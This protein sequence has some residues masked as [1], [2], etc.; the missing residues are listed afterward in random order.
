MLVLVWPWL[1]SLLPAPLLM[2]FFAEKTREQPLLYIPFAQDFAQNTRVNHSSNKQPLLW[3]AYL[4]WLLLLCTV[5]RPEWVGEAV[6]VPRS[7]RD[8][9]LAVDL[10]GSMQVKDFQLNGQTVNRLE[11]IKSVAGAFI[12]QREGD[13]LALILF[14]EQA[15][16]QTPLT[17]DRQTVQTLLNE[18]V[19]GMAGQQT[20]IGDAIGLALKHLDEDQREQRVLILLTDGANTAGEVS[21]KKAAELAKHAGLTIYTI[22]VGADKMLIQT[23]FG[24]QQVNPSQDLD[25]KTLQ[26]IADTTGGRYFRARNSAELASIYQLLDELEPVAHEEEKFRPRISLY[27]W[28]LGFALGLF[29]LLLSLRLRHA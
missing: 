20:A 29:V 9:M 25:E 26:H 12:Q 8:L 3:L 23:L 15:Y 19:I 13:R 10:S 7:G 11:A 2:R 21:P 16:I 17:F 28:P 1:F 24:T 18:A 4:I 27:M 14:G 5:A 6:D 22:G